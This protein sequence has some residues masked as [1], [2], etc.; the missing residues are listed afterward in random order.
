[1]FKKKFIQTISVFL[2]CVATGMYAQVGINTETPY[3]FSALRIVGKGNSG[4]RLPQMSTPY[5]DMMQATSHF[6]AEIT[7]KAMGLQIFNTTTHCVETWNGTKWIAACAAPAASP[8]LTLNCN[9]IYPNE[10]SCIF[11]KSLSA[12]VLLPYTV[13][14]APYTLAAANT[15]SVNGITARISAQTLAA[16]SGN[17]NITLSGNP[18]SKGLFTLPITIGSTVCNIS[19]D[20]SSEVL[21]PSSCSSTST[22]LVFKQADKWYAV[23][24]GQLNSTE[25]AR[26][27]GPYDTEDEALRDPNAVQFCTGSTGYR[28][29]RVFNR[30]GAAVNNYLSFN[31]TGINL[32]GTGIHVITSGTQCTQALK[33]YPGASMQLQYTDGKEYNLGYV[34]ASN[35]LGY[36]GISSNGTAV[37]TTKQLK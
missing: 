24:I 33:V 37:L 34:K 12:S 21:T 4:L 16:G 5:R 35:G 8:V 10:V 19:L 27:F 3:N 25:V 23:G 30:A 26:V 15:G 6:Q 17:I 29:V 18:V 7:G 22:A 2:M 20:I 11:G 32:G 9:G 1:M 28:C 36:L 31:S 13:T 14:A